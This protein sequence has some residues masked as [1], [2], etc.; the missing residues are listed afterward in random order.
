[1]AGFHSS[2]IHTLL[3]MK[4]QQRQ[5]L[6]RHIHVSPDYYGNRSPVA[7][8]RMRSVLVGLGTA[9]SDIHTIY[10]AHVYA[11]AYQLRQIVDTVGSP[12]DVVVMCGG[13]ARRNAV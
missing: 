12:I 4:E 10:L 6:V 3:A 13:L 2:V 9:N 11:F 1:M 7:D 8:E 5:D